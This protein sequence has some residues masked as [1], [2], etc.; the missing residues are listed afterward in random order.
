MCSVLCQT[1]LSSTGK[2]WPDHKLCLIP[3][4]TCSAALSISTKAELSEERQCSGSLQEMLLGDALSLRGI[5]NCSVCKKSIEAALVWR[6]KSVVNCKR[7]RY[8]ASTFVQWCDGS[9]IFT[10]IHHNRFCALVSFFD[11]INLVIPYLLALLS[12]VALGDC[13]TINKLLVTPFLLLCQ[14]SKC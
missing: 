4:I 13:C 8:A 11:I 14:T 5:F 1:L 12:L 2:Y 6:L 10:C 3:F 7:L 9:C